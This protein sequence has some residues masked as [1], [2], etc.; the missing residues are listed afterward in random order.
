MK[1]WVDDVRRPPK[2]YLWV[3]SVFEAIT[4]LVECD[5]RGWDVEIV[6]LDHDAG[7][8]SQ[9][10]GD[11]IK[12]LEWMEHMKRNYPIR[13]HSANPVGIEN[14]RRIINKNGW[15]EVF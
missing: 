5:T 2:G 9:Y 7:E 15:I 10:G 12:I 13:I 6:D 11:Y 3:Q 1:I 14:M 8:Y 4:C